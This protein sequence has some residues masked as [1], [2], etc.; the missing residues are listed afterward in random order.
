MTKTYRI[1][2]NHDRI[3]K[4]ILNLA[5][6]F[7]VSAKNQGRTKDRKSKTLTKIFDRIAINGQQ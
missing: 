6:L 3:V 5:D 7:L 2:N 1:P 4:R